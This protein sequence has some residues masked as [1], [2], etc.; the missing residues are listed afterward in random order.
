LTREGGPLLPRFAAVFIGLVGPVDSL[1][2]DLY[3]LTAAD[4]DN[5]TFFHYAYDPV[6]NRL[7]QTTD[8]ATI[9][10]AYANRL[11]FPASWKERY[12]V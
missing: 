6:G 3:R 4:Y 1:D 9:R 5:G 10:Y 8:S 7:T 11:A 12:T 2:E